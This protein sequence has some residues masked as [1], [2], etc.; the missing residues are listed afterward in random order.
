MPFQPQPEETVLYPAP[1]VPTEPHE[2]V[3]STKRVVQFAPAATG[4]VLPIAEFPLDRIEFVGRMSERP[5]AALGILSFLIGIV[6]LIVS[7]AKVLPA[8]MYAGVA[9]K[10][11]DPA[12]A[13]D[14]P[15]EEDTTGG[16]E[17]RDAND[18][19]PFAKEEA[20]KEGVKE[21]TEKR[22]KKLKGVKFGIPPLSE[23]VI[24]GL[25]ALASG[26]L[27]MGIGRWQYKKE[28]HLVFCRVGEVVY[29]LEVRDTIQQTTILS[30]L[31]A[32]QQAAAKMKK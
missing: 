32:A 2:L 22:L 11:A 3:I 27:A 9:D 29:R 28:R 6:F 4:A 8:A 12:A 5:N 23:D 18:D 25:L 7:V 13:A 24:V 19:D 14:T 17:G 21:K 15:E 10:T 20:A 30:T 26:V 1:F 31:Q 16:I